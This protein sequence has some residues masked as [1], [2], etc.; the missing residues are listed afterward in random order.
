MFTNWLGSTT[1]ARDPQSQS[2][3]FASIHEL[4]F[5]KMEQRGR[6]AI[7]TIYQAGQLAKN[8]KNLMGTYEVLRNQVS[9]AVDS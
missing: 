8:H 9:K 3:L 1:K 7:M 5:F 2:T 6:L 4:K